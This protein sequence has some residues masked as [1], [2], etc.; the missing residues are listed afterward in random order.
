[1]SAEV[2]YDVPKEKVEN[3]PSE[4][5]ALANNLLK[6]CQRLLDELESFRCFIEEAKKNGSSSHTENVVD[7]KQFHV[8]VL[9]EM[10]SLQKV[11]LLVLEFSQIHFIRAAK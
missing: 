2:Q 8:P 7:I 9:T 4:G 6:R 3:L 5:T 10:K 11:R 1:M